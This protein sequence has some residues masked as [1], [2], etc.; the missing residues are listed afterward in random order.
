MPHFTQTSL[1]TQQQSEAGI[2]YI[3]VA[4]FSIVKLGSSFCALD[5]ENN[6]WGKKGYPAYGAQPLIKP[7]RCFCLAHYL[8]CQRK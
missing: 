3:V 1:T 7:V 5:K 8:F 4:K 6:F 2:L